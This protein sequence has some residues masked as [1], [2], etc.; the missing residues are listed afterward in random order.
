V[1]YRFTAPE[2]DESEFQEFVVR[3]LGLREWITLDLGEDGDLLSPTTC[4]ELLA[5]G[6]M[7][8]PAPLTRAH[9]LR[10][11]GGGLWLSGEGGDEVLGPR[12]VSYAVRAARSPRVRAAWSGLGELAP[13]A[14]RIRAAEADYQEHYRAEWLDGELRQRYIH[15]AA[16]LSA[17]EPLRPSEWFGY[18]LARP[19]VKVGHDAVRA[20]MAE[21]GL[22]WEA[23]LVAPAFL[24]ALTGSV[25]WHEYRGRRHL[26][27]A[28]FADLL[29][30]AIIDRRGKVAFNA[31][32]FGPHTR[33]F[34]EEWDG[35]GVP[36]GVDGQWLKNHWQSSEVSAGT[37][38]LLHHV[39]L[40][41]QEIRST[42][43][44]ARC[45]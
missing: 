33:A 38:P 12:R 36:A 17:A 5:G 34:A 45:R 13:K 43:E 14:L 18:Y 40:R 11:L 20:F 28:L 6:P 15:D 21:L 42:R 25:R 9:A 26:L 4:S 16:T 8:P 22:R 19:S 24:G 31:A 35:T 30:K 39:W 1:T 27:R 29:P 3:H 23:P 41:T 7:W 10:A 37:A 32:L 44:G 2:T